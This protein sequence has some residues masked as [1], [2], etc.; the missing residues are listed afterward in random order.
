MTSKILVI[1]DNAEL[2]SAIRYNLAM[3]GHDVSVAHDGPAGLAAAEAEAFDLLILD[4][5]L[6][7]MD[8]Y[9]V[10]E[11]LRAGDMRAPVMILTGKAEEV[12]KVRG[13]RAGA[14]QYVVKP[15]GLLELIERTHALLR[16]WSDA[17][18][19]VIRL[20]DVEIRLRERQV[21]RRGEEIHLAPK[22]YDLLLALV[23]RKGAVASRHELMRDVW[24]HQAEV[25]SRTVD[26]HIAELRRKLESDPARPELILTVWKSGYRI[27]RKRI[28]EE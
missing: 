3:E 24:G 17:G 19:D 28:S 10:L 9:T 11:R 22:A 15:F 4:L 8:G 27:N 20:G 21:L 2:A 23:G 5:M 13:F 12:D 7:G 6:P 16:R 1:E 18:T 14:D 25:L 26:A